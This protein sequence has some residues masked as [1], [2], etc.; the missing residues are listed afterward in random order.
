MDATT[1]TFTHKAARLKSKHD[2]P[3]SE[4]VGVWTDGLMV[5]SEYE[6]GWPM[7]Y[8]FHVGRNYKVTLIIEEKE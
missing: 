7:A 5:S 6:R 2:G 8:R 3:T 4:T 1:I